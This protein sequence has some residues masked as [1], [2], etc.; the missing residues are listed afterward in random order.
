[1]RKFLIIL[2]SLNIVFFIFS[3]LLVGTWFYNNYLVLNAK[4]RRTSAYTPIHD[5]IRLESQVKKING[6]FWPPENPSIARQINDETESQWREYEANRIIPVTAA[7]LQAMGVDPSTAAKLDDEVWGLG[8]DAYVAALDVYHQLHCLN[9]LRQIAYGGLYPKVSGGRDSPIWKIHVDH[10]V[11]IL[12][13]ELQCSGNLNLVPYH[14]VEN[15]DRPFPIFS[16]DRQCIDFEAL[17]RWRLENTIDVD[18]YNRIARKPP[19]VEELRAADDWYKYRA[20]NFTNPNHLDGANPDV[21]F[22]L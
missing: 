1:M 5:L 19:G 14:W 18:K 22:I 21:K 20:P 3:S 15:H 4:F 7:Q 2:S 8:D 17:T 13:Q 12:M 9:T 10:C 6:T 16:I 11:D